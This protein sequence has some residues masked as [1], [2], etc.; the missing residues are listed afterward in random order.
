V[1]AAQPDDDPE[2]MRGDGMPALRDGKMRGPYYTA[3]LHPLRPGCQAKL[4][5]V[6]SQTPWITREKPLFYSFGWEVNVVF[7]TRPFVRMPPRQAKGVWD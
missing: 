2:S 3:F 7:P 5:P 1:R 6:W 4:Q